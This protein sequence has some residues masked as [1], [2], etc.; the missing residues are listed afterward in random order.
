MR[1][2][3]LRRW[4]P[5]IPVVI[6]LLLVYLAMP[7]RMT[8]TISPETTYVTEP[9]DVEGTVD[10][11]TALNDRLSKGI[12]PETNANVLIVK[13]LGPK[14]EG[15]TLPPDYYR[16]LGATEPPEEGKYFI[17]RDKYFQVHLKDRPLDPPDD[18]DDVEWGFNAGDPR[19][20]WDER[21]NRATT[22]PWKAKDEPDIAAWLKQNEKPLA[23]VVEATG[24]PK[25]F[26]PLW[27]KSYDPRSFR[28]INCL[29][30][31]VQKCREVGVALTCRAMGRVADGD[32]DGA[33]QDLLACHR[34]GRLI[35]SNGTMIELLVGIAV[36]NMATTG[37]IVLLGRGKHSSQQIQS[38]V[39]DLQKLPPSQ[40]LADKLDLCERFMTLDSI[41]SIAVSGGRNIDQLADG[42]GAKPAKDQPWGR[43]FT[44][45]ID[46][47]PAFRNA[48]Q[49][50]DRCV[51][52]G[53]LP[54]R[55]SRKQAF[56]EIEADIVARKKSITISPISNP[57]MSKGQRGEQVGDNLIVLF[58]PAAQKVHDAQD[59]SEQTQRNLQVAFA[60]AAYRA[61]TGRYPAKLDEL[62]P[63]YLPKVPGD[64]FSGGPLIYRPDADSYLLYSV[65]VNGIDEDGR[66]TDDDPK[67]DDPR[68]RIP[69]PEPAKKN[70]DH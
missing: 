68:V 10:Y 48:N 34:L 7:G 9:R 32:F 16:W 49:M 21:V 69:V 50:F 6:T 41:M 40:L 12:T 43:L 39:A 59:R 55:A 47:D 62:T 26:N 4:W 67:G 17:G 31:T 29:L 24:R 65:G 54:D 53:R 42:L 63:K 33:W 28:L 36:E 70:A 56:A 25:Y 64:L 38:W 19:Q 20:L 5:V 45:S 52:A 46:F 14:P 22:W 1:L 13:A 66:W 23:L 37:E 8:Y 15:G 51:A 44:N 18:P 61:D 60:L 27:S 57:F 58:L 3:R 2:R 35:G 11:P 30:P